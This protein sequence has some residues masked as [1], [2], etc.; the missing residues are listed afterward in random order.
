MHNYISNQNMI[1]GRPPCIR[2]AKTNKFSHLK[3][4]MCC[5]KTDQK[6]SKTTLNTPKQLPDE[7]YLLTGKI[8]EK[9][10]LQI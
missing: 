8:L 6:A 7:K 1:T 10:I 9:L 3:N 2:Q 5:E 4:C